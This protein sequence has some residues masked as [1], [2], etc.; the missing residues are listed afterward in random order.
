METKKFRANYILI[1]AFT[2]FIALLGSYITKSEMSWYQ[3]IN[4]PSWA[5][6]GMLIGIVWTIIF[7]LT[8]KSALIVWNS[9]YPKIK[10]VGIVMSMFLINAMLNVWWSTLFFG[11]HMIGLAI[12]DSIL[13][14][15]SV[16]ILIILIWPIRRS[17]S[18]LLVP[19]LAW[20]SFATYLN[21]LIFILNK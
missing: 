17:A 10:R 19:Y 21:Y 13:L 6:S 16:L 8:A 2:I 4:I 1:P 3:G 7:I 11:Q 9:K 18:L 12:F 15:L 14:G 20:V 5:P